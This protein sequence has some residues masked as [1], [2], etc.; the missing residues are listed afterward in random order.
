[1]VKLIL[2]FGA[3][4]LF[5]TAAFASCEGEYNHGGRNFDSAGELLEE[6]NVRFDRMKS[7]IAK[8]VQDTLEIC[9]LAFRAEQGFAHAWK[10]YHS[11]HT[12]FTYAVNACE[13]QNLAF[14]KEMRNRAEQ[15]R[16]HAGDQEKILR[17][18]QYENCK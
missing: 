15:F 5:S 3:A 14:A 4:L 11:A 9:S 1:M 18:W 17:E 8:P 10:V 2:P 13:G 6:A 16:D 7:A 12:R